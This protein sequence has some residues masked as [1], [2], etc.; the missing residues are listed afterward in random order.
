VSRYDLDEPNR[1]FFSVEYKLEIPCH[2]HYARHKKYRASVLGGLCGVFS[3]PSETVCLRRARTAGWSVRV[4]GRSV[5]P[6]CC[7]LI[8]RKPKARRAAI[9]ERRDAAAW[10]L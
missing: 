9:V 6:D 3:G 4:M 5:C 2:G 1:L 7:R 8:L 10:A